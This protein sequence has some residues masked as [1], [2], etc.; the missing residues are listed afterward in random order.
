LQD[1]KWLL[2]GYNQLLFEKMQ[3]PNQ[4]VYLDGLL[5]L[6]ESKLFQGSLL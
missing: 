2:H 1:N 4:T 6:D 5:L 3:M